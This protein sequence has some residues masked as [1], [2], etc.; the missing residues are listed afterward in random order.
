MA[1]SDGGT[2]EVGMRERGLRFD[3]LKAR[4][5]V[6]GFL[7]AVCLRARALK[8][9]RVDV[10]EACPWASRQQPIRNQSM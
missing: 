10:L 9:V 7:E 4:E 1:L 3:H 6:P 2:E 8:V 5:Q